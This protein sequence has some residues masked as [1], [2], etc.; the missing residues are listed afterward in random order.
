M[1]GIRNVSEHLWRE[2]RNIQ[3]IATSCCLTAAALP[4]PHPSNT[5][6]LRTNATLPNISQSKFTNFQDLN[7]LT[8]N[9][10]HNST[11]YDTQ[12]HTPRK[13]PV[14]MD[15]LMP[16]SNAVPCNATLQH[17]PCN[18][19]HQRCPCNLAM[20]HTNAALAMPRTNTALAT[21][22]SN[23]AP[24]NCPTVSCTQLNTLDG[25]R[26]ICTPFFVPATSNTIPTYAVCTVD[27]L[28]LHSGV[29]P[30]VHEHY[31]VGTRQVHAQSSSLMS[32]TCVCV[33]TFICGWHT[34]GSRPEQQPDEQYMRMC[35]HFYMWLAHVRFTP[36]A[37]A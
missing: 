26:T 7:H 16:H 35:V 33:C 11:P 8:S 24:C 27:G 28:L 15:L 29:P 19:T 3:A 5:S 34:S 17:C 32:N 10:T 22:H 20:P 21:P 6:K 36:R 18:A 31:V 13:I 14:P 4:T 37:A 9:A 25:Q 23:A 12:H 2:E 30:K 1:P